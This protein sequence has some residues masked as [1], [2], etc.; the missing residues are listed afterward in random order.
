[1]DCL[2]D[3][4]NILWV[5]KKQITASPMLAHVIHRRLKGMLG[6]WNKKSHKNIKAKNIKT[7]VFLLLSIFKNPSDHSKSFLL[8]LNLPALNSLKVNQTL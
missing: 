5:D 2:S 3:L 6:A 7:T 4:Q 1:M 8:I